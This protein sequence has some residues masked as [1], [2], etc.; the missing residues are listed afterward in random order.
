MLTVTNFGISF[1]PGQASGVFDTTLVTASYVG[2]LL[3]NSVVIM[4]HPKSQKCL[5][6]EQ[7]RMLD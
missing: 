2:I 6:A 1:F 7:Y 5:S 3:C 4:L